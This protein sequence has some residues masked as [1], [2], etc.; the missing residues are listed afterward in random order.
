[1]SENKEQPGV[2]KT[3][4][5]FNSTVGLL[6]LDDRRMI[7]EQAI[8]LME[9]LY[10]HLPLKAAIHG[11]DPLQRLRV[12]RRRL[13]GP[14][15]VSD[16]SSLE[17]DFHKEM[18]DIFISLR[19]GHTS[20][21]LPKPFNNY[22]AVL[23]FLVES[24]VK[25]VQNQ[26][27]VTQVGFPDWLNVPANLI[28][29]LPPTFK[30]GVEI[31]YWNG[32][33]IQ[34]AVEINANINSG[35]NPS[36]R[37]ARGLD[38]M[39]IRPLS[40]SLPPDEE[41]VV[42]GY[43]TEEG[44]NL[45]FRLEWVIVSIVPKNTKIGVSSGRSK[46]SHRIGIDNT[47]DLVRKM[48]QSL[49]AP[50]EVMVSLQQLDRGQITEP[51]ITAAEGLDT[52][53]KQIFK[54]KKI[55][56]NVG[57][58]RIY[59]FSPDDVNPDYLVE[60]FRRLIM[61]LPKKGLIIDIRGNGGGDIPFAERLLQFLS[62][63]EII[64]EPYQF[65]TSD[66]T[67]EMT[68]DTSDRE[69][70][71]WDLNT[72]YPSLLESM[73]TG[74]IFSQGYPITTGSEANNVGQIYHG[75]VILITDALCYSATDLFAASFQDHKIGTIL[76]VDRNTGAGGGNNMYYYDVQWILGT[77]GSK[78]HL[79]DLPFDSDLEFAVRR[80]VR[81]GER[82][83]TPVEDLGIIP[84]EL[85]NMTYNDL[86]EG[87]ADLISKA[88]EILAS[89]PVRQ[90]DVVLTPQTNSLKIDLTTLGVSRIDIY[91]DDI[92]SHS[93]NIADGNNVVNIDELGSAKVVKI[94]GFEGTDLVAARK[95]F[96][97]TGD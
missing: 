39:T 7:V 88:S 2:T 32:V 15:L 34:R 9:H 16:K 45:E 20:Y 71:S 5:E 83:G 63:R 79:D 36:A 91:V 73:T 74:S 65:I 81:V 51:M 68:R 13:D 78:Y 12:L 30:K 38:T 85:Y 62:P 24:Y 37:F 11:V 87:N 93:Q 77:L 40:T 72:W 54:A 96:L 75:P 76:G 47:T 89:K 14:T 28:Q 25:E 67:L 66:L 31:T 50:R 44:K 80:N 58:I 55:S 21:R 33:P 48:K 42:I 49:F 29:T 60:E 22:Y 61:Q 1:M 35:S 92:P 70:K 18:L 57:Y 64:T 27:V 4:K 53:F 43:R 82:A 19:D 94:L 10:V 56:D 90:I 6:T 97:S 41:W 95:V 69:L 84:D 23:P 86:L 26:F 3:L 17:I 59:T 46:N 52:V 8:F